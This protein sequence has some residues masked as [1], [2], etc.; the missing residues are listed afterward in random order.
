MPVIQVQIPDIPDRAAAEELLLDIIAIKGGRFES[1]TLLYKAFYLAHLYYWED[2]DG[3][4]THYPI[5]RMPNGPGLDRGDELLAGLVKAERLTRDIEPFGPYRT[6]VFTLVEPRAIDPSSPRQEAIRKALAFIG[7][8]TATQVC[9]EIHEFSKSW[10]RGAS[11][12]ELSIYL[13]LLTDVDLQRLDEAS[14][15]VG[16]LLKQALA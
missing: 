1:K 13:D 5:V 14:D 11:G 4:L 6:E 15:E 10:K 2:N 8:K 3:V 9:D 12:D 7:N 16:K